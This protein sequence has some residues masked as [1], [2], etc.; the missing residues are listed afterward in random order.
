[1]ELKRLNG[2]LEKGNTYSIKSGEYTNISINIR[3]SGTKDKPIT[4]QADGEV[5]FSSMSSLR[6]TGDYIIF[7]G[8]HFQSIKKNKMIKLEGNHIRFTKNLINDLDKDVEQII[9][10]LGKS[11]RIDNNKVLSINKLGVVIQVVVDKDE[12]SYCLIDNNNFNGRKEQDK[13]GGEVIRIGDSKTHTF[14]SRSIVYGNNFN[15]CNGDIEVVSVKSG[16]NVIYNNRFIDCKGGLVFRHGDDN[17]AVYNYFNGEMAE[18]N[19]DACGLR[20]VGKSHRVYFNTFE[21]IINDNPFRSALS[22]MCGELNPN[23]NGYQGVEMCE[24]RFN[25]FI[26]CKNVMSLG[27]NN[28]RKSNIKPKKLTITNNRFIK[29]KNMYNTSSKIKGYEDCVITDNDLIKFDQKLRLEKSFNLDN[30]N[31]EYFWDRSF[32]RDYTKIL[33]VL[34]VI[35]KQE[36]SKDEILKKQQ[37]ELNDKLDKIKQRRDNEIDYEMPEPPRLFDRCC[38]VK[39]DKGDLVITDDDCKDDDCDVKKQMMDKLLEL[40]ELVNNNL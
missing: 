4:I 24:I 23:P 15:F 27:V 11:N 30:M 16:Q 7:Q 8:F 33:K 19:P 37:E 34:P 29:C 2:K 31:I 32:N 21:R 35:E 18:D 6:I 39:M 25:D 28:K 20:L 5:I 3:S 26:L 1:M 40:M 9:R 17:L 14:N 10:V 13:N 12:P 36:E 38:G 22:V